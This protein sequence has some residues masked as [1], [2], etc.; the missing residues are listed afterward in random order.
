MDIL[1]AA[2]NPAD[3]YCS[4]LPITSFLDYNGQSKTEGENAYR[5]A[6]LII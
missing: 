1:K 6:M 3:Y 5:K 4:P 2:F